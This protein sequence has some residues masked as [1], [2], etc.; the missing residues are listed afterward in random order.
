MK[1]YKKIL[2][3]YGIVGLGF[4]GSAVE[5]SMQSM[6]NIK[7]VDIDPE[8]STHTIDQLGDCEGIFVCVP[9]PQADDGVCDTSA[10]EDV[11]TK[12]EYY[13]GPI[14]SKCTA[15]PAFYKKLSEKYINL[16]HAPEFLT[17]AN[18]MRDYILGTFAMIGGSSKEFIAEAERII[19]IGQK[20]LKEVR[21]CSVEEAA[22]AKYGINTFLATKVVF[23]NELYLL[24]EKTGVD[25]YNVAN[26]IKL[27][28]RIGA[29]H[30]KVPGADGFGFAGMCFPKDTSA[31]YHYAKS[32]DVDMEH[33]KS[34][35]EVNK[36]LRKISK[37][38]G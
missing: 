14:I 9:T 29:T 19:R 21:H 23:M 32:N 24:C 34:V 10:L 25:F 5:N 37:S 16:I 35:I 13:R 8:K 31:L 22:L 1:N 18:A 12:L 2:P 11:L 20:N 7:V 30:M 4:V 28:S 15:P 17:A 6:T 38:Q 33:M 3:T 36:K 27:D 26:L